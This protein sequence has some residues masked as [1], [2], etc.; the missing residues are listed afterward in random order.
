MVTALYASLAA[1]W[2]YYLAL[3]VIK[4]RR[5]ERIAYGD[6]KIDALIKARSAHGNAVENSLIILLLLF[7]LEFNGA[8]IILIHIVG[9]LFLIGRVFHAQAMLEFNLKKRTF[10]MVLTLLV[11]LFLVVANLIYL[12]YEKLFSF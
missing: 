2:I 10:S 4:V 8:P 1:L 3:K 9:V 7:A 12:P 11:A 6:Q 5:K